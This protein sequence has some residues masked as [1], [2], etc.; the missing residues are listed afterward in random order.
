MIDKPLDQ[1]GVADLEALVTYGRS[2]GRSL[3]FK[4]IFPGAGEKAV[5]DFLADVSAFANTDGGDIVIG[6]RE[7]GNGVAAEIVGISAA[8]LDTDLLRIE[9][10]LRNCIDPRIPQFRVQTITLASGA[11]VLVMRVGASTVA[12][13]RVTYNKSSRFYGRNSRG[14]YEMGTGELRQAFAASDEMPRKIRDLHHRAVEA[15]TGKDMPCRLAEVP[16]AVLTVAPMSVLREARD[17]RVTR[18]TAVLPP[19]VS[20]G[21]DMVIGL[22]GLVV[23][24]PID[25]DS[26][27][28][29][30]WSVN[31][32][33]GY[34]DFAWAIGRTK[35]GQKIIWRKY[36][37]EQVI[38]AARSA[39][40]RLRSFGIEGPWVAMATLTGI[41]D[42]RVIT[43]DDYFTDAAWQDPAYLGEV[44]DD[45]LG[46]ESLQPF[47]DGFWRLFG[48]DEAPRS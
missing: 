16:A 24:S 28:V 31:H 12:P 23:H 33:R 32:R 7:D 29:R 5:K 41:R 20:G 34:V 42:Y 38:G 43:G 19:R 1:I 6:V 47:I 46:P 15:T 25:Q 17:I 11:A 26:N 22:D 48:I 8:T 9:D 14:N 2:E 10:Q 21:I 45:T 36:F 3:D 30:T 44:V 37:D 27:A 39:V 40:A 4:L 35:D 18:E 13:H